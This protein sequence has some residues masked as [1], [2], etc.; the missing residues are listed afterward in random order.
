[1]GGDFGE[2][3]EE[4]LFS[5]MDGV[6]KRGSS[7]FGYCNNFYLEARRNGLRLTL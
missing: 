2:F 7:M 4:G 3:K 1:M 6:R 5:G